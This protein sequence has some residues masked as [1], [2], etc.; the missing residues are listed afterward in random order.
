MINRNRNY[1]EV[2]YQTKSPSFYREAKLRLDL[3]DL[4]HHNE[5]IDVS[6]V[7]MPPTYL[8]VYHLPTRYVCM[9]PLQPEVTLG[10]FCLDRHNIFLYNLRKQRLSCPSLLLNDNS[11]STGC[12]FPVT[13]ALKK[14]K[15]PGA[16]HPSRRRSKHSLT[17]R[18]T[19][20]PCVLTLTSS[21]LGILFSW[22]KFDRSRIT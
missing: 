1:S 19:S 17:H 15:T 2:L 20:N 22:R 12:R 14:A 4:G 16:A 13:H 21:W 3:K 7:F 5:Y 6:R 11:R 10:Y 8:S 9:H 18:L